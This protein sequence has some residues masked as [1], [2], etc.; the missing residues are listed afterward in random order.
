MQVEFD[1]VDYRSS[2]SIVIQYDPL[3]KDMLAFTTTG[4]A[5]ARLRVRTWPIREP[6]PG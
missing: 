1:D 2:A 6:I 3:T 5:P 4:G